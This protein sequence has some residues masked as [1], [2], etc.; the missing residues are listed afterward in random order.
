MTIR[1]SYGLILIGLT[2]RILRNISLTTDVEFILSQI[3]KLEAELKTAEFTVSLTAMNQLNKLIKAIATIK[4]QGKTEK[5][6]LETKNNI[7]DEMEHVE[8][9]VFAEAITK[10]IYVIPE[11]RYNGNYLLNEPNKL[12]KDSIFGK[13]TDMAKFDFSAACRCLSFGEGTACAFHILRA[14]EDTLK[15]YYFLHKKT[16]R[17][18]KPMWGP[19]T[20]ELRAKRSNR[21]DE[22]ILATLDLV[23]TAY[24]NP[25]QHPLAKYDI[26]S[27][28]DLFGVCVDL[29]NK[30]GAEL[31]IVP[32][33]VPLHPISNP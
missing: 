8:K 30:M 9:V 10:K 19:M 14:T 25:T 21:P 11:R 5:P 2:I 4:A 1:H 18:S 12:L 15:Q 17:L 29:I 28:Q 13:L 32:P 31:S 26:D 6:S 3:T 20:I 27:A 16:K 7:T 24:R 23:R 22:T 33:N